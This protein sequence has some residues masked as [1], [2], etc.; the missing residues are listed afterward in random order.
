MLKLPISRVPEIQNI[1]DIFKFHLR[2]GAYERIIR[3][4]LI[5]QWGDEYETEANGYVDTTL[6]LVDN[7][8]I[9]HTIIHLLNNQDRA[10]ISQHIENASLYVTYQMLYEYEFRCDCDLSN[11]SFN[12]LPV[13]L[14]IKLDSS[15]NAD[16]AYL[17][18]DPA[19]AT[20]SRITYWELIQLT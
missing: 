2:Q 5:A 20:D 18:Y 9:A 7:G 15:C 1:L 11:N 16:T 17:T 3:D 19:F 13:E 6:E 8:S 14:E 12:P 10:Y 4:S